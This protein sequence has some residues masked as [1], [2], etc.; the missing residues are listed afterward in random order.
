MT[1]LAYIALVFAATVMAG[2]LGVLAHFWRAHAKIIPEDL[3]L[4]EPLNTLTREDYQFEKYVVRA[5]WDD[6]G[7]WDG[8]SARNLVYYVLSSAGAALAAGAIGWGYRGQI[9]MEFCRVSASLGLGPPIC[10]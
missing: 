3:G 6:N 8:E 5:D 10:F 2:L 1:G 4:G 7:Y 9:V